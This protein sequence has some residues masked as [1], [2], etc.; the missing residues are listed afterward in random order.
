MRLI[1]RHSRRFTPRQVDY[2]YPE[3]RSHRS[4][5]RKGF[6]DR[7]DGGAVSDTTTRTRETQR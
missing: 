4:S 2:T 1:R 7:P 5:G 3:L 6:L